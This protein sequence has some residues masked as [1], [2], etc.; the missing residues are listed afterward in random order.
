L[1]KIKELINTYKIPQCQRT[2]LED[3]VQHLD[4]HIIFKFNPITPLYFVL[5]NNN[6]YIIDGLHRME[7][8]KKYNYL[9]EEKIPIVE[10]HASTLTELNN[11]FTLINDN[12]QL[13]EIYKNNDIEIEDIKLSENNQLIK[14]NIIIET[15]NHFI[16]NYPNS[17]KY[18]GR[19]RPF[20]DNNKFMDQLSYI[21]DNV[22]NLEISPIKS[23]DTFIELLNKLNDK[24]KLQNIDWYPSKGKKQNKDLKYQEEMDFIVGY[25]PRNK[26]IR[27]LA[28]DQKG[29]TLVL[30]QYVEKHGKLLYDMIWAKCQDR[31]TFFVYGGTETEQRENIRKITEDENDAIIVASYGT[32]ST[33]INIKNLHNIIF[34]SP[35]KSRIRNLQSIGRGLR[36]GDKKVVCNLYDIGDDMTW[37][38][39]KNFTLLHMIE[40]LKI[41]A[42]EQFDYTL[43][44]VNI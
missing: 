16:Q 44:Q 21:Y 1:I 10:I 13:H 6:R 24:Y 11:Y 19:R 9:L 26:F 8:Y 2:I 39:R 4:N 29:N 40:R 42:D 14:K 36:R 7:V 28:L 3:R 18:N 25:F 38:A 5:F 22:S 32:F 27:N 33:G 30:F 37:K 12:M 41:Y 17:F 31:K 23:S 43:V 35:S 34:A 15:Y 20:L